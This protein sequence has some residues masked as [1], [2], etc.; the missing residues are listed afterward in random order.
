MP[1]FGSTMPFSRCS[2]YTSVSSTDPPPLTPCPV[3]VPNLN[4]RDLRAPV[5]PLFPHARRAHAPRAPRRTTRPAAPWLRRPPGAR[6]G[7]PRAGAH[8]PP[9]P[10]AP[11]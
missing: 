11:P 4:F 9:P 1:L 5:A 3:D 7:A 8:P 10:P 6:L 2:H